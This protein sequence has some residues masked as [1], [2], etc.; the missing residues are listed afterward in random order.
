[1]QGEKNVAPACHVG[2]KVMRK[3]NVFGDERWQ[4]TN[5]EE[6]KYQSVDDEH[7]RWPFP[8]KERKKNRL[9]AKEI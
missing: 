1:M 2:H 6:S 5:S 3:K 9:L 8:L 4:G 7:Y